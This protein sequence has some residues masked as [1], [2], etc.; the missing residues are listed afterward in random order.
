MQ[1]YAGVPMGNLRKSLALVLISLCLISLVELA[2]A[3]ATIQTKVLAI[4]SQYSSIHDAIRNACDGE[5]ILVKAGTYQES[6]INTTKSL[7]IIG[8]GS[9]RTIL[10]IICPVFHGDVY[11]HNVTSFGRAIEINANDFTFSGFT[12]QT[13]GGDIYF[14]GNNSAITN[15]K[16]AAPLSA[17]GYYLNITD[18][19]FLKAHFTS[20]FGLIS[21]ITLTVLCI[22]PT[23]PATLFLMTT[24]C[25]KWASAENML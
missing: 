19:E 15:N 8:E 11:G 21:I 22:C 7:S 4:P 6:P 20:G 17:N 12:I 23:S 5:I 1:G 24:T 10:N 13:N 18:N 3:T 25:A 14:Q 2:H 16:I 9:Q